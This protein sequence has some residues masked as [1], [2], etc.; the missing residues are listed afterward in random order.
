[1]NN[2]TDFPPLA[3]VGIKN[4]HPQEEEEEEDKEI[5]MSETSEYHSRGRR[6]LDVS[7]KRGRGRGRGGYRNVGDRAAECLED[8][9]Q[10]EHVPR[11]KTYVWFVPLN[12]TRYVISST[13][14]EYSKALYKI[15]CQIEEIQKRLMD[16]QYDRP[17][18]GRCFV[19][20]S[21][22]HTDAAELMEQQPEEFAQFI[23]NQL[24][25]LEAIRLH[26]IEREQAD[27]V[28]GRSDCSMIATTF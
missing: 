20:P 21:F 22:G 28:L 11:M 17:H 24:A 5:Q 9:K 2:E 1:M 26:M 7:R 15:Q 23:Q 8:E 3:A 25:C 18:N 12:G 19:F 13:S 10:E 6:A 4:N 27:I 14:R 16:G